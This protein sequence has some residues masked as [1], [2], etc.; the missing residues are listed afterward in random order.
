MHGCIEKRF[1][2]PVADPHD[3]LSRRLQEREIQAELMRDNR[4]RTLL[5]PE[6]LDDA[7][8]VDLRLIDSEID[9][10]ASLAPIQLQQ[11]SEPLPLLERLIEE[12]R[13][14]HRDLKEELPAGFW[15]EQGTLYKEGRLVLLKNSVL[16]T[17]LI[18]E[19]HGQVSLAHPSPHKTYQLLKNRFYWTGMETDIE[20]FVNNCVDCKKTKTFDNLVSTSSSFLVW[21]RDPR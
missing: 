7:V 16:T 3:V 2:T 9:T 8:L 20:R 18:E 4:Y 12:N 14:S 13:Q 15:L 11:V 17:R 21:T 5:T 1:W 19:A 10:M 6:R